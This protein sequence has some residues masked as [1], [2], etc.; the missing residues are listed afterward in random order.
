MKLIKTF[1]PTFIIGIAFWT[2]S[3]EPH[4][5]ELAQKINEAIRKYSDFSGAVLVAKKGEIV[6]SKGYGFADYEHKIPNTNKT[7]FP[8]AS[9]TKSFTALPIMQLQERKLL[10]VN[11]S[12]SIFIANY[13]AGKTMTIHHL[14]TH[15]S[16][17]PNYYAHFSDIADCSNL[18]DMIEKVKNWPLSFEPGSQFCY[19]NT[20]Y[21]LLAYIIEKVS[22]MT[23]GAFLSENIF[24]P[25]GMYKTGS[26]PA[27]IETRASGYVK[28]ALELKKC[29]HPFAPLTLLGNGDLHS[30]LEDMFLWD[31]ALD[32]QKLITHAS[33]LYMIKPHVLMK[34]YSTRG[35]A[36]GWFIDDYKGSKIVEYSG[37]LRGFL[38]K[39]I[40]FIDDKITIIVLSNVEGVECFDLLC[41]D[42][43]SIVKT[44]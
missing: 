4:E 18:K 10:N 17:I 7:A 32:E 28:E 12:V 44:V 36:Y 37:S 33:M 14:L 20:G 16:G 3:N 23:Y 2:C 39:H 27:E 30:C 15:T 31:R 1:L 38:A 6:L 24:K 11:D 22:G 40:K 35:H 13:P 25:M 8:I 29:P 42:L 9:L 21:L 34:D 41:K 5:V 19:S 43:Y 26:E